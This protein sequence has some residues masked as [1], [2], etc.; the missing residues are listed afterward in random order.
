MDHLDHQRM[1]RDPSFRPFQHPALTDQ[2]IDGFKGGQIHP[3]PKTDRRHTAVPHQRQA[4]QDLLLL[5]TQVTGIEHRADMPKSGIYR[6]SAGYG[7]RQ[8]ALHISLLQQCQHLVRTEKAG[9]HLLGNQFHRISVAGNPVKNLLQAVLVALFHTLAIVF[10]ENVQQHIKIL[11]GLHPE[12]RIPRMGI[13]GG[14]DHMVAALQ[15]FVQVR[16]P[17]HIKIIYDQQG[18]LTGNALQHPQLPQEKGPLIFC[19]LLRLQIL[20]GDRLFVANQ[21][22]EAA[23]IADKQRLLVFLLES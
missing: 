13:A 18:F 20:N 19:G 21:A 12:R 11:H 6:L 9:A 15:E 14:K 23:L 2:L 1:Q 4:A 17:I 16:V 3:L 10:L 22:L 7:L 5:V 8:S